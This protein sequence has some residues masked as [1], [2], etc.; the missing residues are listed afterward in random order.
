MDMDTDMQIEKFCAGY[1]N[2]LSD[3]LDLSDWS[4]VA[5]QLKGNDYG[6]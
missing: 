5:Q 4:N 1:A 2:K 6:Y 3:V